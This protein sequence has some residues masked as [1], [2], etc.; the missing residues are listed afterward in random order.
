M[1]DPSRHPSVLITGAT[2][3]VGRALLERL[4]C[5]S[6][7]VRALVRDAGGL[8]EKLRDGVD[9]VEADLTDRA[10]LGPA[11][12]GIETA[13]YLVHSMEAGV[14]GFA[15]ADRKSAENFVAAAQ[16]A[17][18]RRTVYLGGVGPDGESDSEHLESREEVEGI[19]GEAGELVALRASM[20]VGCRSGSFRSMVQLIDRMPVLL[21]PSWR[22]RRSQPVAIADVVEA[23]AVARDVDA[24]AYEIAGPDTLT[25]EEMTEVVAELLGKEHRSLPL[26]LSNAKIEGFAGS[27]VTDAD[28][29]LLEPLMAGLHSDLL[30]DENSLPTVF[31]VELTPFRDAAATAIE[32]MRAEEDGPL[33]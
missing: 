8:P 2:G 20:V 3:F 21:L 9:V 30:V 19:L 11:L 4:H 23:L 14:A 5:E 22:D 25:F 29:E 28:S 27:V 18:L 24:A 31:G 26:P 15:D 6:S 17:G 7:T 1:P 33:E 13:Y 32:E 12:E 16:E 10:S